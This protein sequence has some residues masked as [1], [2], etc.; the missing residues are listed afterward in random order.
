[1]LV[2]LTIAAMLMSI[3]VPSFR[4]VTNSNRMSGEINNLLGDLQYA[5]S[6]ALK[7]GQNVTVCSSTDGDKCSTTPWDRGWIVFSDPTAAQS[8]A[9]KLALRVQPGFTGTDTLTFDN[10]VH[11][12]TFT[13]DGFAR[14][15]FKFPP[16]SAITATLHDKTTNTVWTRCLVVTTGRITTEKAGAAGATQ[17]TE[18]K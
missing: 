15:P 17:L 13:R 1:L 5:R 2:V 9:N 4:Y 7:E 18:C 12:I 16:K 14:E 6:E 10:G 8:S 11:A 3:G